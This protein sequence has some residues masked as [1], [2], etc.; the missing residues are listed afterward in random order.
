M[1]E[2]IPSLLSVG[3]AGSVTVSKATFSSEGLPRL[4]LRESALPGQII[5][6]EPA[7]RCCPAPELEFSLNYIPR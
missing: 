2:V 6:R 3:V 1:S 5:V 4:L 7:H